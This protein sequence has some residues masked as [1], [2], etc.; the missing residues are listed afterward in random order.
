MKKKMS[1]IVK[2]LKTTYADKMKKE[3]PLDPFH[4]FQ[5]QQGSKA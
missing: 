5:C 3:N 1:I 4:C 2:Q